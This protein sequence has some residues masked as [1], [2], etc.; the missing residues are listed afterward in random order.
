MDDSVHSV[1]ANWMPTLDLERRVETFNQRVHAI[2]GAIQRA[3][4]AQLSEG[5]TRNCLAKKLSLIEQALKSADA[6]FE[7]DVP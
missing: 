4:S 5:K 6:C 2:E 3:R 1:Y 7:D